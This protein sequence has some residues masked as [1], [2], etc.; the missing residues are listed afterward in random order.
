VAELT[1]VLLTEPTLAPGLAPTVAPGF[2][3]RDL[4]PLTWLGDQVAQA[5][6]DGWTAAMVACWSA[7][8]WL[9]RLALGLIDA[10]TNPDVSA[11]GPLQAILPYTFAVG[12]TLAA[13]TGM[14]QICVALWRRDGA[15]LAQLLV[16]LAQFGAVWVGVLAFAAAQVVGV[17]GL[18][19]ALMHALLGIDSFAAYQPAATLPRQVTDATV[20][21][22]LGVCSLLLIIGAVG[23]IVIMLVREAALM[24]LTATSVIAAAGLLSVFSTAWFYKCVRWFYAAL[25]I[26]PLAVLVLGLGTKSAQGVIAGHGQSTQAAVGMAVV[27]CVLILI[28]AF[29]PLLLFRL[30]AFVDPGT[31]SGQSFRA[32]MAGAGGLSG[33]LG[34]GPAAASASAAGAGGTGGMGGS[35]PAAAGASGAGGR[36]RGESDAETAT[37]SRFA[38]S[39]G[40]LGPGVGAAAERMASGAHTAAA[41]G[42]DVL[43]MAG[44]GD[45]S[46][47][48]GM[49][50]EVRRAG[51]AA[52]HTPTTPAGTAGRGGGP[53]TSP[54]GGPDGG[55]GEDPGGG[56]GG[57]RGDPTS[58]AEGA[59]SPAGGLPPTW[60]PDQPRFTAPAPASGASPPPM[61]GPDAAG[62]AGAGTGAAAGGAAAAA[63][64]IIPA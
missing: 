54:D 36:S 57:T 60:Q 51:P 1:G 11:N 37:A 7:G 61:A 63:V 34:A 42:A 21:T 9:L 41:I 50:P 28:A 56:G 33:L 32:S 44:V 59:P 46:P 13:V 14:V 30:L 5:A 19:S 45:S 24:V 48:F 22:V 10:F 25:F 62:G 17:A 15:S 43:A 38:G 8:M 2:A 4:S 31:A 40:M 27:S 20:A 29:C 55:L 47:Y 16:G 18:T 35:G 6:V 52:H 53:D 26:P 64:P 39:L 12:G 58:G 23:F 3:L 49:P